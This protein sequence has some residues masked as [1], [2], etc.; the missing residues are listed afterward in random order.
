VFYFIL[1]L[2]LKC[3]KYTK[4]QLHPYKGA[5]YK[6][7]FDL[8]LYFALKL[9]SAVHFNNISKTREVIM[10]CHVKIYLSHT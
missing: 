5:S 2:K 8:I 1:H 6:L 3:I 4:L 7:Y 9:I 10:K